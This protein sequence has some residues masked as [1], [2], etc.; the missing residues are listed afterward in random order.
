MRAIRRD[1]RDAP[2]RIADVPA[3]FHDF[4]YGLRLAETW[5][6]RSFK[7]LQYLANPE[8]TRVLKLGS[9]WRML[10]SVLGRPLALGRLWQRALSGSGSSAA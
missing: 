10:Y 6:S 7:L 3:L 4:C 5:R 1:E 9:E 2:P 8:D